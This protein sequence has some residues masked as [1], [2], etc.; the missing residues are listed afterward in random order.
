MLL[1]RRRRRPVEVVDA[2]RWRGLCG[3]ALL[4]G[5][6]GVERLLAELRAAAQRNAAYDREAALDALLDAPPELWLQLDRFARRTEQQRLELHGGDLLGLLLASLD[7]DGRLRQAAV[8]RLA[9]TGGPLAVSALALRTADWVTPVRERA[10]AAL[11]RRTAPDEAAAAVRL[12]IRLRDRHRSGGLIEAYGRVLA[13]PERRRAVRALAADEDPPTRRFGV[14]LA[15]ELGEYVRGDLLRTALRDP[16]QACRRLCAQRL[17]ELD[18]EQAGRLLGSRS[19]V[20]RELAVAALPDDVPAARLV[21]PLADRARIVRAQARWRLY[22]RGEP[23]VDVYRKQLAKC[24]P[25]TPARLAAGLATG[26]GE[27]GEASDVALLRRLTA[28]VPPVAWPPLVRRSAVH[29]IG[30]LVRPADRVTVLAPLAL[31]P[32][33]GVAREVFEALLP[34]AGSVP[35][36]TIWLGR[37]HSESSVRRA[38]DRLLRAAKSA[39][40]ERPDTA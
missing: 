35:L 34:V 28:P 36:E 13:E 25:S 8:E 18:P 27:C 6:P 2:A 29:A 11:T 12:L 38:A 20:V 1:R 19:A 23:P 21:G 10:V 16:D 37:A 5:A 22:S 3:D 15:L 33:P 9:G 26:L 7:R 32:D 24:G 40:H 17:L 30:R 31:D 14:G 39:G 4:G